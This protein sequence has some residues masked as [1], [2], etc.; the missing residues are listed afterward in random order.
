M[1]FIVPKSMCE[2]MQV[3]LPQDMFV[4]EQDGKHINGLNILP[5]VKGKAL[6][7]DAEQAEVLVARFRC[8]DFI[9]AYALMENDRYGVRVRRS[10]VY[11]VLR[12][13]R[14]AQQR[15]QSLWQTEQQVDSIVK[16][17]KKSKLP[18]STQK[19]FCLPMMIPS[20]YRNLKI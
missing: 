15:G 7:H 13:L 19:I 2:N 17:I 4:C 10:R 14:D 11:F 12:C 8:I 20:S 16:G 6:D 3:P 9:C 5:R 18:R 1:S